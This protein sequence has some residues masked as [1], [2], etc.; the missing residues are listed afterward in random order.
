MRRKPLYVL[1]GHNPGLLIKGNIDINN[2]PSVKNKFVGGTSSVWSTS[3]GAEVDG[4]EVEILVPRVVNGQVVTRPQAEMH[5]YK[6]G[7]HLGIFDNAVHANLYA[8]KLHL[9]QAALSRPSGSNK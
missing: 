6:T 8:N 2:R 7:Q 3:F 1:P 4:R 5:Y 9:Q